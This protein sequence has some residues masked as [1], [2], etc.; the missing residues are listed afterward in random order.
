MSESTQLAAIHHALRLSQGD[1]AD[2]S[3]RWLR[4]G[5]SSWIKCGGSVPLER[6]LSLPTTPAKYKLLRRNFWL[7]RAAETIDSKSAWQGVTMLADELETFV[8]RGPWRVW[9]DLDSPPA[10][11]SELRTALFYVAKAHQDGGDEA[12]LLTARQ[13]DRLVGSVFSRKCQSTR[14]SIKV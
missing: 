13:I 14:A 8:T 5:L 3:I 6:C 7:A 4:A 2:E 12:K 9:R 10:D 1:A 11:A